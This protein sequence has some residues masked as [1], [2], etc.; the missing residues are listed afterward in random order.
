M[1]N[2]SQLSIVTQMA[3]G[4]D[5]NN[6]TSQGSSLGDDQAISIKKGPGNNRFHVLA[7]LR[8]CRTQGRN[9]ARVHE[10]SI[11]RRRSQRSGELRR[12]RFTSEFQRILQFGEVD[13]A[14][15]DVLPV[16]GHVDYDGP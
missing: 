5:L 6:G 10:T 4:F 13:R 2:E 12:D 1:K 14:R 15:I 11:R 9:K 7:F 16:T 8:G 3:G